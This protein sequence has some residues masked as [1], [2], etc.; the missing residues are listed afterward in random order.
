MKEKEG[1]LHTSML[2]L[3]L[4]AI[5]FRS[6]HHRTPCTVVNLCYSSKKKHL[7]TLEIVETFTIHNIYSLPIYFFI[8]SRFQ[9][10]TYLL[11]MSFQC[12]SFIQAHCCLKKTFGLTFLPRKDIQCILMGVIHGIIWDHIWNIW[13]TPFQVNW[14]QMRPRG[15]KVGIW[16]NEIFS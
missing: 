5:L 10:Q 2:P 13:F 9:V 6:F 16:E 8:K 11:R 15:W 12:L 7:E 4:R 1:L 3:G 14:D